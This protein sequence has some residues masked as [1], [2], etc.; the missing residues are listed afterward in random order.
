MTRSPAPGQLTTAR[1]TTEKARTSTAEKRATAPGPNHTPVLQWVRNILSTP[2][3][4]FLLTFTFNIFGGSTRIGLKADLQ[5]RFPLSI[6][7]PLNIACVIPLSAP[8]SGK[9]Q[10]VSMQVQLTCLV[11]ILAHRS[12]TF[13]WNLSG[14]NSTD[15]P[16]VEASFD[17]VQLNKFFFLIFWPHRGMWDLSSQRRDWTHAP[18]VGSVVLTT[19]SFL[20]AYVYLSFGFIFEPLVSFILPTFSLIN[21]W[22]KSLTC[23]Y[24]YESHDF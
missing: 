21:Y 22:V 23:L 5:T 20:T 8:L 1:T 14:R 24:L 18:C 6:L 4:S 10:E 15:F 17:L 7:W 11:T 2:S 3:N 19:G 13:K 12:L 16:T 9:R